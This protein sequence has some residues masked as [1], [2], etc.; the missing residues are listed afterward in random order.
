M[1]G[2]SNE[3][4]AV[5][6]I[7][8]KEDKYVDEFIQYYL[9]GLGF[10]KLYIYDNSQENTLKDLPNKYPNVV[11]IHF[12]G[13]GK[14]SLAYNDWLTKNRALPED[15]RMNWCAFLDADEFIVL[16]KHNNITEFLREYCKEGGIAL[17][18]Y[19][20]GDSKHTEPTDEPI[21]KRFTWRCSTVNQHIKTII[22]CSDTEMIDN[23]HAVRKYMNGKELKDTGGKKITGLYNPNGPTDIAVINHYFTKTRPEFS[24]K[25][26]RGKADALDIRKDSEFDSHNC[27]ETQDDSAYKIYLKAQESMPKS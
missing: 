23:I 7:M 18:W 1:K 15:E 14:Q 5:C 21:T 25:R 19:L 3:K 22:K 24:I 26:A 20:Y 2:G 16:K 27:N 9:Y 8:I 13:K 10:S 17:N 4:S 6:T 11:I 12:P